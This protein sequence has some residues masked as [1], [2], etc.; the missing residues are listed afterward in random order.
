MLAVDSIPLDSIQ[1]LVVGPAVALV[2]VIIA[3]IAF[4]QGRVRS[5]SQVDKDTT[6]LR[7]ERDSWKTLA[8]QTTPELKRLNDLLETA[9]KLLLDRRT[10]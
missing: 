1:T 6:A 2:L 3:V 5:G 9:V 4:V 8:Q 7:E 10:P